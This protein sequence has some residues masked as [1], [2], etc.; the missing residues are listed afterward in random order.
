MA[1]A[2]G[3]E[4]DRVRDAAQ[5]GLSVLYPIPRGRGRRGI[6]EPLDRQQALAA[7]TRGISVPAIEMT[8]TRPLAI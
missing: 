3:A 7:V 2:V 8:A 5:F 6:S 1:L 4:P